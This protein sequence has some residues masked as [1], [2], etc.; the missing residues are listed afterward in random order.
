MCPFVD[1]RSEINYYPVGFEY[2]KKKT[3]Y[4][5]KQNTPGLIH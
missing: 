2:P 5:E 3:I 1:R 4:E